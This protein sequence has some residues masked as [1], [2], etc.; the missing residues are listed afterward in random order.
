[1]SDYLNLKTPNLR[2][3]LTAA[4][5]E[6]ISKDLGS[7]KYRR[8][9]YCNGRA[10]DKSED[11]KV[12]FGCESYEVCL[13]STIECTRMMIESEVNRMTEILSKIGESLENE[14]PSKEEAIESLKRI[15]DMCGESFCDI[16]N[17]V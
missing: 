12:C 11:A 15:V 3:M 13:A 7:P 9:K 1:M 16:G 2:E 14:E 17:C 5:A 4:L 6:R 8:T 10:E